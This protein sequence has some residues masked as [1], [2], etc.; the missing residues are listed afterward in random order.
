M[1]TNKEVDKM[2][3][4]LPP[5]TE[6]EALEVAN[7]LLWQELGRMIEERDELKRQLDIA[8][9]SLINL[10]KT[11]AA[12]LEKINHDYI[13]LQQYPDGIAGDADVSGSSL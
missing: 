5:F 11:I 3:E 7:R 8:N 12:E 6:T 1:D 10:G 2:I 9:L 13:G 4:A